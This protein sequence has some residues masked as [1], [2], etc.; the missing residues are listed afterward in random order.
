MYNGHIPIKVEHLYFFIELFDNLLIVKP[1]R[2]YFRTPAFRGVVP[3][4][5]AARE[6]HYQDPLLP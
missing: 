6:L 5:Y 2:I 3:A 1:L 4:A